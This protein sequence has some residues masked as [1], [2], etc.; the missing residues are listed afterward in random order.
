MHPFCDINVTLTSLTC[1]L[2]I[3]VHLQD[4][5]LYL[6]TQMI[7]AFTSFVTPPVMPVLIKSFGQLWSQ[8][9]TGQFPTFSIKQRSKV[10]CFVILQS[11][12]S[13]FQGFQVP[14]NP[15]VSG[16]MPFVSGIEILPN[17]SLL[18]F[19]SLRRHCQ[20][21]TAVLPLSANWHLHDVASVLSF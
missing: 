10:G 16:W 19:V 11:S 7:L 1:S 17:W 9:W 20:S 4:I 8:I 2:A 13:K 6:N 5:Q 14:R 12:I 21:F 18:Q 3:L 15:W